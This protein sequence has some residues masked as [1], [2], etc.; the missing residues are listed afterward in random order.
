MVP[1]L[2][3]WCWVSSLLS[4]IV[5]PSRSISPWAVTQTLNL[6]SIQNC[7]HLILRDM[8]VLWPTQQHIRGSGVRWS[9]SV[10][11]CVICSLVFMWPGNMSK[12]M[13]VNERLFWFTITLGSLKLTP[14]GNTPDTLN[15]NNNCLDFADL[16]LVA[17]AEYRP[18]IGHQWPD[19]ATRFY[20]LTP[21]TGHQLVSIF[22]RT[23]AEVSVWDLIICV[24]GTKQKTS[25]HIWPSILII[26]IVTAIMENISFDEN[27]LKM[28]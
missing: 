12:I 3:P 28:F 9:R 20:W 16:W 14:F 2:N 1:G 27:S 5:S 6:S 4:P 15:G 11:A 10:A 23:P 17:R 26:D 22:V 18:P 24:L 13:T 25:K 21:T 8:M 19:L 7:K